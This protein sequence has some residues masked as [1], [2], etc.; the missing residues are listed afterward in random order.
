MRTKFKCQNGAE[1]GFAYSYDGN[2][3]QK[4]Q[5]G[6]TVQ[7]LYGGG[8][9]AP[10]A[11]YNANTGEWTNHVMVHGEMWEME[12]PHGAR[13]LHKDPLGNLIALSDENGNVTDTFEYDPFGKQI[14]RTGTTECDYGFIG[15]HGV[16]KL[17]NGLL[18]M[19]RRQYDPSV[20]RFTTADPIG[21]AGGDLNF[22]RYVESV[23]KGNE[24][25][26]SYAES[27]GK[28]GVNAY[29]YAQNNPLR[30]IDPLGLSETEGDKAPGDYSEYRPSYP[31]APDK[32]LEDQTAYIVAAVV[33]AEMVPWNSNQYLRIG[34]SRHGG[35]KVY[36]LA[37]K[38]VEAIKKSGHLDF[39]HGGPL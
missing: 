13:Y 36:R 28:P 18:L 19:G 4:V 37:G 5:A 3:M 31:P 29:V 22:Y 26:Y 9:A 32:P 8:G 15:G 6:V 1:D 24:N 10:L 27:V 21:F 14:A 34:C 11:E 20:G 39:W 7:Y 35:E 17:P 38:V 30:F 33:A 16:R 25:T 2:L 23:G 12:T